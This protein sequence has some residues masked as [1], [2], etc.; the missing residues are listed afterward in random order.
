MAKIIYGAVWWRHIIG[1]LSPLPFKNE[2]QLVFLRSRQFSRHFFSR[3]FRWLAAPLSSKLK[4][5]HAT[6][7]VIS[8]FVELYSSWQKSRKDD[9]K[10]LILWFSQFPKFW[11]LSLKMIVQVGGLQ[12]LRG[13][14]KTKIK[15][16]FWP[17]YD[18]LFVIKF[19]SNCYHHKIVIISLWDKKN[20]FVTVLWS[21]G[22][23]GGEDQNFEKGRFSQN[24]PYNTMRSFR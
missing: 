4:M 22:Y 20:R 3:L 9:G 10:L 16:A 8:W 6:E 11:I 13:M 7:F 24:Q 18:C 5:P 2:Y 14:E 12:N 17:Y 21:H 15:S 23:S 19:S 1:Y